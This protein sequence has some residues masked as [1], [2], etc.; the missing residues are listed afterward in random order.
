MS[1]TWSRKRWEFF[2]RT[3]C[4]LVCCSCYRELLMKSGKQSNPLCRG[5]IEVLEQ[6]GLESLGLAYRGP[7]DFDNGKD[8][9]ATRQLLEHFADNIC[10]DLDKLF[11]IK[12]LYEQTLIYARYGAKAAKVEVEA[13]K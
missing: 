8:R 3:V 5:L 9:T 7:K 12:E 4:T 2:K 6:D 1:K 10:D 11:L 13:K